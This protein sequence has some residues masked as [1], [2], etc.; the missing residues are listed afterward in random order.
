MQGFLYEDRLRIAAELDGAA[1]IVSRFVY[2]TRTN[3]PEY[4]V[5]N[6]S[7]YRIMTDHL[8][9]PRLVIDA[10]DG[11]VA[12]QMAYDEFGRVL[13]DTNPGFQP[14][15]FA[16]GLYDGDTG[17][18]R[19]GARDYDATVGRWT[20]KDPSGIGGYDT[21]WYRYT[22]GD[23]VNFVDFGGEVALVLALPPALVALGD[24]ALFTGGAIVAWAS[25][26][27]L[28]ES[29]SGDED[30]DAADEEDE[31]CPIN[32]PMDPT[33][34][35]GEGWE[36]RGNGPPGSREG[37]WYNPASGES[38]HPDFGHPSPIGPH[39]D[40]NRPGGGRGW[41][42]PPGGGRMSPKR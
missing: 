17:L 20:L 33:E 36:W 32:V 13:L 27:Y 29:L 11:T 25:G 18:I 23:P 35:P 5:K 37:S 8:G 6:G 24:A 22:S 19:F 31:E 4:M 39:Y 30:R 42:V 21:N 16:G 26:A 41:R 38:L 14:F 15:G 28:A 34:S 3:V 1:N 12:Q 7:T 10:S 2:G 9:S 40:Y